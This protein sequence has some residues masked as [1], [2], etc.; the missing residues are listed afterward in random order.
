[1][2]VSTVKVIEQLTTLYLPFKQNGTKRTQNGSKMVLK[3]SP[4]TSAQGVT[5]DKCMHMQRKAS[6]NP[7]GAA[8]LCICNLFWEKVGKY[9]FEIRAKFGLLGVIWDSYIMEN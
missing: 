8:V 9:N 2:F 7:E 6:K 5:P 1:M 3:W 4:A